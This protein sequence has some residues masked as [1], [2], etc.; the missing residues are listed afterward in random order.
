MH[1]RSSG[2]APSSSSSS[3]TSDPLAP[4]GRD[5]FFRQGEA[6][7]PP[8]S[9]PARV[10]TEHGA[11]WRVVSRHGELVAD[12]AGALRHRARDRLDLPVVGD[13]VRIAPR[14]RE[15]KATIV[16]VDRRRSRLVRGAAGGQ[17]VQV[18]AANVDVVLVVTAL[19]RD[20][21]P[22]RIERALAAIWEGGATPV[23]VLNKADL[24]AEPD[25]LA[26]E[27]R[28]AAPGV[29]VLLVSALTGTGLD[30]VRAAIR[31]PGT[32]PRTAALLGSSGVGKSTLVNAL[33]GGLRQDTGPARQDDDR[34]RH[35]TTRRDLL[36]VPD[37]GVVVDTPGIREL[38]LW[39][40]E[41]GEVFT[42]VEELAKGCRFDDCAHV[43]EPGCAVR[44]AAERGQLD[45]ARLESWV[46]LGR[47]LAFQQKKQDV[48]ARRAEG[49]RFGK[50][51]REGEARGRAKREAFD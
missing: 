49:R 37:L 9:E 8:G 35:T 47:E 24:Q 51:T 30:E 2:S 25:A 10:T 3:P 44:D 23:V 34:G 15:G 43:S 29:E 6:T 48:R 45:P 39:E 11:T 50:L 5:D 32:R 22:R 14:P 41:V 1:H 16:A 17:G 46:K 21:N 33:L 40:G 18:V 27:L 42:D 31:G 28:Q 19:N 4:W 26:E 36:L 13:W 12:L 20:L 38:A 7:A